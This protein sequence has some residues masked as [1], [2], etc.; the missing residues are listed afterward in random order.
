MS[1]TLKEIVSDE[2][3]LISQIYENEGVLNK[4]LEEELNLI[5]HQSTEKIDNYYNFI[6][7]LKI[8]IERWKEEKKKIDTLLKSL[9]STKD[10]LQNNLKFSMQKLEVNKLEGTNYQFKLF[11]SRPKVEVVNEDDIPSLY[12]NQETV[13]KLDKE[14]IR[15]KLLAGHSVKGCK[16]EPVFGVRSALRKDVE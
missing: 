16:L 5:K 7:R 10:Y 3:N 2:V 4:E 15:E 13:F 9:N 12:F 14:K 8:E 11:Q 6:E 1:K